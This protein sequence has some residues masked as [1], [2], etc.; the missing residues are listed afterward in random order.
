MGQAFSVCPSALSAARGPAPSGFYWPQCLLCRCA[1]VSLLVLQLLPESSGK[2]PLHPGPRGL[3]IGEAQDG[4]R[5]GVLGPLRT[6]HWETSSSPGSDLG[7]RPH[8]EQGRW[9]WHWADHG[10]TRPQTRAAAG[11]LTRLPLAW[12]SPLLTPRAGL[13]DATNRPACPSLSCCYIQAG[14]RGARRKTSSTA[15]PQRH[16]P[17]VTLQHPACSS[18]G[19][20]GAFSSEAMGL[21]VGA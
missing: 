8:P 16:R 6:T 17:P 3:P 21:G 12:G 10:G 11:P 13:C 1:V 14:G 20:E 5:P 2:H 7:S 9:L 15:P 19:R 4:L 18:P